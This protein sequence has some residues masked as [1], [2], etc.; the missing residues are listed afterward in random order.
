M[1]NRCV[2]DEGFVGQ[3]CNM[4][5]ESHSG[6]FTVLHDP[7]REDL[8]NSSPAFRSGHS[9]VTYG[10][11]LF[12]YGGL[13]LTDGELA[14]LYYYDITNDGH[15]KLFND[16]VSKR[17][18]HAVAVDPAGK[19]YVYGGIS[20]GRVVSEFRVINLNTGQESL[21]QVNGIYSYDLHFISVQT[22]KYGAPVPC[23][24]LTAK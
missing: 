19:M 24:K 1:L 22:H 2:C 7:I 8:Y 14:G 20:A 21:M 23:N 5:T 10:N 13:S 11:K 6:I 16:N 4:T 15:W 18:F 12:L 3:A 17:Y 9:L